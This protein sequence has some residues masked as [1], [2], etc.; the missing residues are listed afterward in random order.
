MI[1]AAQYAAGWRLVDDPDAAPAPCPASGQL[2]ALF[3]GS[4]RPAWATCPACGRMLRVIADELGAT[5]P[6]HEPPAGDPRDGSPT[7]GL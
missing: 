1:S 4:T 7:L 2:L 5:L 3:A 6:D